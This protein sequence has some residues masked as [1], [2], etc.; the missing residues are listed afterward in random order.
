[1]RLA[2]ALLCFACLFGAAASHAPAHPRWTQ[3]RHRAHRRR[4]A[5]AT[6]LVPAPKRFLPPPELERRMS[7]FATA[8]YLLGFK[9]IATVVR[10]RTKQMVLE[11]AINAGD[12]A[13][14]GLAMSGGL[15]STTHSHLLAACRIPD[16]KLLE[17]CFAAASR[18]ADISQPP[19]KHAAAEQLPAGIAFHD[20]SWKPMIA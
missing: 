13:S 18:N 17:I 5:E 11:G 7:A 19:G 2:T 16:Y 1:M 15:T 9:A 6:A 8:T 20:L 14:S 10:C 4:T 3:L 12:I